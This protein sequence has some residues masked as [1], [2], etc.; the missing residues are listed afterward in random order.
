MRVGQPEIPKEPGW[1][2][3]VRPSP[4]FLVGEGVVL[5][6]TRGKAR[7]WTANWAGVDVIF[8]GPQIIDT[9]MF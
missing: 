6:G 9:V 2:E 1:K 3:R 4:S 8:K 7:S 5:S